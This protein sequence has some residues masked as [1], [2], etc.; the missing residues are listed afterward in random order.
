MAQE[1]RPTARDGSGEPSY[2]KRRLRR[3]VLREDLPS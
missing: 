1:S 2:G 3:A